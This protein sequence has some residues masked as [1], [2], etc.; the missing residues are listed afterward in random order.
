[1]NKVT[2]NRQQGDQEKQD[3]GK[4]LKVNACLVPQDDGG[5]C[6]ARALVYEAGGG[7]SGGSGN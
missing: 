2:V 7:L 6:G 3:K 4:E 5:A 1:M